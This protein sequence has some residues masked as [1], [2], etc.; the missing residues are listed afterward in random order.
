MLFDFYLLSANTWMGEVWEAVLGVFR[1]FCTT[2]LLQSD[3]PG[4]LPLD[5]FLAT[6]LLIQPFSHL[7]LFY[8]CLSAL[9]ILLIIHKVYLTEL[10]KGNTNLLTFILQIGVL[11][12]MV[13]YTFNHKNSLNC[14]M[15]LFHGEFHGVYRSKSYFSQIKKNTL[16][17]F[18]LVW[19]VDV[20]LIA[21][22]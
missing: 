14:L 8:N 15:Q 21:K 5:P 7:S 13:S 10:F 17:W 19:F 11:I 3:S 18:S 1:C 20:I 2:D 9:H 4:G 12:L 6:N 22:D 16:F